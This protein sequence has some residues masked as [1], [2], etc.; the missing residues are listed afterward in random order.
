[1]LTLEELYEIRHALEFGKNVDSYLDECE[2]A[3]KIINR[4]IKERE[5][6]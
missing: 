1:M 3:L 2:E 4:E 6:S 5:S